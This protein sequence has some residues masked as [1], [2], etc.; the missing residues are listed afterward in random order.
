MAKKDIIKKGRP[1]SEQSHLIEVRALYMQKL[2]DK[3][4]SKKD[5]AFIFN[6]HPSQVTRS[7][8]LIFK[9]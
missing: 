6:V 3:N 4:F 1:L 7:L 2:I 5:V 9:P 8:T